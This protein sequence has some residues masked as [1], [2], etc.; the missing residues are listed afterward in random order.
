MNKVPEYDSLSNI[1]P[2]YYPTIVLNNEV[3]KLIVPLFAVFNYRTS[4]IS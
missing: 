2:F 1:Q 4:N 3:I